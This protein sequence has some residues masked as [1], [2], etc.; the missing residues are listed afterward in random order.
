MVDKISELGGNAQIVSFETLGHN[1]GIDFAYRNT[2]L[3]KWLLSQQKGK[4]KWIKEYL[5]EMF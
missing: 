5:W 1:D 4:R 3:L 2:D